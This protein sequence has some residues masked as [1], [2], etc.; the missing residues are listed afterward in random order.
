MKKGEHYSG[1]W[2]YCE[3]CRAPNREEWPKRYFDKKA[4]CKSCYA[5]LRFANQGAEMPA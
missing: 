4:V 2:W 5:L 1:K 3:H